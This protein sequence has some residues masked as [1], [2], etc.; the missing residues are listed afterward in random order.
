MSSFKQG[1]PL[2]DAFDEDGQDDNDGYDPTY[3]MPK[4]KIHLKTLC[5]RNYLIIAG[6]AVVVSLLVLVCLVAIPLSLI[7]LK[8]RPGEEIVVLGNVTK[9]DLDTKQYRAIRLSNNLRVLLVSDSEAEECAAAMDV[10]VG[11]FSDPKEYQGLA[12]FCEHMLFYANEKYP[13]E[14]AYAEFLSSHGGYDNAFTST[15]NTNYH[16][17]VSSDYLKEALD[18]FAQFFISPVFSSSAV[19]REVNAVDAEHRKNLQN[20]DWRLWQ[21]LK[22]VS[23]PDHPFHGFSTGDLETLDKPGVLDGLKDFYSAH[24]SANEV[25]NCQYSNVMVELSVVHILYCTCVVIDSNVFRN[26]F[27][28]LVYTII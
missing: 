12:H 7:H 3:S 23:N 1:I 5:K 17:K 16:F 21:L 13:E 27:Q 28:C 9:S 11:S 18:R 4:G 2:L 8:G 22:Q 15:Q 20:D 26:V 19:G 10:A 14:G 6:I 25:I 24:Y